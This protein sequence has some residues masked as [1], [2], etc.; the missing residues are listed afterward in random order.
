MR[1]PRPAMAGPAAHFDR[2]ESHVIY[3]IGHWRRAAADRRDHNPPPRITIVCETVHQAP[4][5]LRWI[6]PYGDQSGC[7]EADR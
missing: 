4:P 6:D 5:G 1:P 2:N 7:A 3:G